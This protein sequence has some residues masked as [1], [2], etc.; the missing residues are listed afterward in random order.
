MRKMTNENR[1]SR[2]QVLIYW[3]CLGSK[4]ISEFIGQKVEAIKLS[5]KLD[6]DSTRKVTLA[7]DGGECK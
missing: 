6:E 5:V 7:V 3:R 1:L 4:C 2:L